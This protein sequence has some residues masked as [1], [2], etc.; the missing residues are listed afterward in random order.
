MLFKYLDDC[1]IDEYA[2]NL[3]EHANWAL[4]KFE[5]KKSLIDPCIVAIYVSNMENHI[6]HVDYMQNPFGNTRVMGNLNV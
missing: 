4:F 3:S 6:E 5:G 1:L 2:S